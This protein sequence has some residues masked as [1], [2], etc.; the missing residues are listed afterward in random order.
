MICLRRRSIIHGALLLAS[1][2]VFAG[3][4]NISRVITIAVA[5]ERYA[6]DL[7][8]G[9][10]HDVLGYICLAVAALLLSADGFL[11]FVADPVPNIARPGRLA[12]FRNP[13]IRLWNQF[14]AVIPSSRNRM[15]GVV[16]RN[17]EVQEDG[18]EPTDAQQRKFPRG[19]ELFKPVNAFHF[20]WG[21]AESWIFSREYTQLRAG[22]PFAAVAIGGAM[23]AAWLNDA[24]VDPLIVRYENA[25][26]AAVQSKDAVRQ[27][28]YLRALDSLRPAYLKFK[29]YRRINLSHSL[30][31]C[32]SC[33]QC[34]VRLSGTIRLKFGVQ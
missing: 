18:D 21:W 15:Y 4:M 9:L 12:L 31:R 5:W 34:L 25:Y 7:T 32:H 1:G 14:V 24:A 30:L 2:I 19:I 13:L 11:G 29:H 6:T 10:S 33:F 16:Q 28:T 3:L 26:D 8:S 20:S 17:S 22:F 23:F 27:E